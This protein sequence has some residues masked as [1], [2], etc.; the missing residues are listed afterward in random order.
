LIDADVAV[1]FTFEGP[2]LNI[3]ATLAVRLSHSRLF[4]KKELWKNA[5]T[6]TTK[7]GGTYG[8]VL[9][10]IAEGRADLILFF[11]DGATEENFALF[12]QF[13]EEHLK[14]RVLPD[15]IRRR[16]IFICPECRTPV[17]ETQVERRRA[18]GFTSLSCS[19]C[20]ATISL[21]DQQK[22]PSPMVKKLSKDADR[23]RDNGAALS[24]LE[25]KIKSHDHDIFFCYNR[26]D[27]AEVKH[28]GG[29]LKQKGY[30]PWMDV[31]ELQAGG[32][33][34]DEIEEQIKKINAAAVFVGKHGLSTWQR[35]EIRIIH[36]LCVE[37]GCKAIPVI[38]PDVPQE[39]PGLPVFLQSRTWVD[40]RQGHEVALQRF[41]EGIE[42]E[43][44]DIDF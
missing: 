17:T 3:Y 20:D 21:D 6:Y 22:K 33:W 13:V 24:M 10:V 18:R 25:G 14:R 43:E 30:L 27:E 29:Q 23:E 7:E 16:K 36:F 1:I 38:L 28:I 4:I 41:M 32:R 11:D 37:K 12:E 35:D 15:T 31:W 40:F 19:V 8:L 34:P 42:G 9:H 2:L 5:I 44:H 39:P 26:K